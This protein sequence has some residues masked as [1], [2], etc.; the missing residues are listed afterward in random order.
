MVNHYK[1][2]YHHFGSETVNCEK[3]GKRNLHVEQKHKAV[4]MSLGG[5]CIK[6]IQFS[7][8]N[9]NVPQLIFL[10]RYILPTHAH[11]SMA[12]LL[13]VMVIPHINYHL[14]FRSDSLDVILFGPTA[15]Q[16]NMS[17]DII[18]G[19]GDFSA[20]NRSG[21]GYSKWHSKNTIQTGKNND[22]WFLIST[23]D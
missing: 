12:K 17:I 11:I 8:T 20:G 4:C 16:T 14:F 3:K 18:S 6:F 22:N 1:C 7:T 13:I 23:S 5:E 2:L 15:W 10:I 21:F 9:G 19:V